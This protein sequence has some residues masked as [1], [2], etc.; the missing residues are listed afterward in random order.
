MVADEEDEYDDDLPPVEEELPVE[1][2]YDD[3]DE[4]ADGDER[5]YEDLGETDARP[6]R[7]PRIQITVLHRDE[8]FEAIDKPTGLATVS[9]R[10][11]PHAPTVISELWRHWRREDADVVK[12]HVVHRLDRGT[13][14]V[15]LFARHR[16]AQVALREQFRL[17]TVQKSYLALVQGIPAEPQ[18]L[19]EVELLP[20]PRHLGKMRT[21]RRGGKECRT[22]YEV[23]ETFRDHAWVQLRP[24]QGRTHQIRV[25]LEAIGHPCAIDDLYG[26]SE[27]ILMSRYKRNY[28]TGRGR[29]ERPLLG[30]LPLHA[31]TLE[32]DHPGTGERMTIEAPLPKDLASTLR[33]LRKWAPGR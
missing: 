7:R 31:A 9:E 6:K 15:L 33:Q 18:G 23:I 17:R 8:H 25:S 16:D 20:D 1:E 26:S 28:R 3:A 27:P 19:I 21:A 5:E 30:R 2:P 32:L 29:E 10:W 11:N 24:H 22:E 13:T 12:P 14:G 4:I